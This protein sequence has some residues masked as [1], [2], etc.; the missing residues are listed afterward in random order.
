MNLLKPS[1]ALSLLCQPCLADLFPNGDFENGGTSWEEVADPAADYS[2]SYPATEGNPGGFG[3]INHSS[4]AGYGLWVATDGALITLDSL[5]L[6]AGFTYTFSQDMKILGGPNMAGNSQ[7]G[8]LKIE[9]Y[10]GPSNGTNT[11]DQKQDRIG[12][13]T[14]WETYDFVVDIPVG[15]ESIKVVPV[16]GVGLEVG[17]DNIGFDPNG[18]ETPPTPPEP[19]PNAFFE[20]GRT[21]WLEQGDASF[22]YP[23]TGGNPD[24]YGSII[25]TTGGFWT[26][27]DGAPLDLGPL[28]IE[29]GETVTFKVDMKSDSG[30]VGGLRLE[31][32]D[33]PAIVL[34]TDNV[35]PSTIGDGTTWETY[36][37]EVTVPASAKAVKVNVL[38][39]AGSTIDFDNVIIGDGVAPPP[40]PD[41][42][43]A[44]SE[45]VFGT[46]FNW[47]GTNPSNFF[48]PQISEDEVTWTNL[49]PAF[50]GNR[51]GQ[52][53]DPSN[54]KFSRVLEAPA[55]SGEA[56]TN[57]DF[58][59]NDTNCPTSWTCFSTSSQVPTVITTDAFE[60][61]NS[62]RIAVQ[63]DASGAINKPE[64][65]QNITSAG[66]T[67]TEGESYD[68]SF[69]A[70]SISAG[71]GY[72]QQFALRWLN[73]EGGII[74]EAIPF[75]PITGPIGT[76]TEFKRTGL[77]APAGA[78]TA[79]FEMFA[80]AGAVENVDA[81][82]EVLIDNVSLEGESG[83]GA[84][85]VL[86]TSGQ[87]TGVGIE[88]STVDGLTYQAQ[89]GY[90]MEDFDNL[91]PAFEGN[92]GRA[93][94]GIQ[95]DED[96]T[97]FR[98]LESQ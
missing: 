61:S 3:I 48:Q 74:E 19:I 79:L 52:A 72:V 69:Q 34:N 49:G 89:I 41:N 1:L 57:G 95:Y 21:S 90:T 46:L 40:N 97:F 12:D 83:L 29:P 82:G 84:G 60:G 64:I 81:K 11:G 17:F 27:A 65:Q 67:I 5:G 13:G 36:E 4:E 50:T 68:F 87:E 33:G 32:F 73:D 24:G 30:S 94:V 14:T 45:L 37:L 98:F 58:E 2:F 63:N 78:V 22:D 96:F 76:W 70:K 77:I 86:A 9:F 10:G 71:T 56:I 35:F 25:S 51:I 39:R 85:T 93:A 23:S 42:I 75:G 88:F 54:A 26:A 38:G 62:L 6:T 43:P 28:G 18:I 92:G 53:F 66:G 91:G 7:T 80:T 59:D 8:G 55:V 44:P 31:F 15:T 20:E 16:W 47:S